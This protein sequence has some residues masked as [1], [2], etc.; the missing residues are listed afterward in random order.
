[1]AGMLGSMAQSSKQ[2]RPTAGKRRRIV[3][4]TKARNDKGLGLDDCPFALI[5]SKDGKWLFALVPYGIR[6]LPSD[7]SSVERSIDLPHPRPSLWEGDDHELWIGGHHL[8]KA[9]AFSGAPSKAGTKLSGWVD[10]IV[11]LQRDELLLGVGPQG[12]ILVDRKSLQEHFRRQHPHPGPFDLCALASDKAMICHGQSVGHILDLNH[13]KGYTQIGFKDKDT[14]DNPAQR[15]CLSYHNPTCHPSRLFFAAC[16]GSVA[17]TGQGMRLEASL[18]LAKP[19]RHTKPL[20]MYADKRWLYLLLE[21]GVLH[22]HLLTPLKLKKKD[23]DP[24]K[25]AKVAHDPLPGAQKTRLPKIATAMA[26]HTQAPNPDLNP[27]PN[28]APD[29]CLQFG[30]GQAKGQLGLVW[31]VKPDELDWETLALG[32]RQQSSPPEARSPNFVAT[33][34]RFDAPKLSDR[35]TVDDILTGQSELWITGNQVS[36]VTE[37]SIKAL[38]ADEVMPLDSLILPAMLRLAN[39]DARPGWVYWEPHHDTASLRYFVWGDNPRAWIELSTP[40]IRAQKW[41][42]TDVFPL[43]VA[44]RSDSIGS[45]P[46]CSDSRYAALPGAWMDPELFAAM[47]KEC[48]QRLKVLW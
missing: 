18:Y 16:D 29:T 11:G 45:L 13:L 7:L 39:S 17:W 38:G 42:R 48:R 15:L 27:D 26:G 40:D 35:L 5:P 32:P 4:G 46:Q 14:W 24:R 43:Q 20:A 22:R 2:P 23:P 3:A 1:M 10:H 47:A 31:K 44:L 9:H 25:R 33:R 28:Q 34:H 8:Y 30:S 41:S 19:A 37:R 36:R 12:E 21:G 6:V